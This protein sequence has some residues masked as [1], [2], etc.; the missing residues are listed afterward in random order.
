MTMGTA[1][2]GHVCATGPGLGQ[3]A[4]PAHVFRGVSTEYVTM[5]N[6]L[7]ILA[8]LVRTVLLG[9]VSTVACMEIVWM[10]D[11]SVTF[12]TQ[13]QLATKYA[14][15]ETAVTEGDASMGSVSVT[16]AGPEL[17]VQLM[18]FVNFALPHVSMV[19]AIWKLG[20]VLVK[21]VLLVPRARTLYPASATAAFMDLVSTKRVFVTWDTPGEFAMNES[22]VLPTMGK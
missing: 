5:V 9:A 20:L 8:F 2:T 16:L 6:A 21:R 3:L 7:A 22:W 15:Q 17:I 13:G 14:A 19:N 12:T 4:P 10:A 11:A 18:P 1:T